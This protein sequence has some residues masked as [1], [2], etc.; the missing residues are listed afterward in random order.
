MNVNKWE[1]PLQYKCWNGTIMEIGKRTQKERTLY[2]ETTRGMI[3]CLGL[4]CWN[5]I[6]SWVRYPIVRVAIL[7]IVHRECHK[8]IELLLHKQTKNLARKHLVQVL[9]ATV[10]VSSTI[11]IQLVD[12]GNTTLILVGVS[13]VPAVVLY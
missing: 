8:Q 11:A 1:T 2:G 7:V 6:I 10:L 3:W 4:S 12:V 13:Q 5:I 9:L